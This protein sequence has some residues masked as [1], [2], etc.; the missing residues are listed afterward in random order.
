MVLI[1]LLHL[2][3]IHDYIADQF[4]PRREISVTKLRAITKSPNGVNIQKSLDLYRHWCK[5]PQG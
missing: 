5:L 2:Y 1:Q 4:V 3:N